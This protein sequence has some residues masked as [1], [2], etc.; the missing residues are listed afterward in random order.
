MNS[1]VINSFKI[2]A[3]DVTLTWRLRNILI[4]KKNMVI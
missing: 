3:T 4:F 2:I 1:K